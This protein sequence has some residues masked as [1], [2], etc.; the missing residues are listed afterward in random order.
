MKQTA[1]I[2]GAYNAIAL[3]GI[4]I[5]VTSCD[6]NLR[7]NGNGRDVSESSSDTV[8]VVEAQKELKPIKRL[9]AECRRLMVEPER[10]LGRMD[11]LLTISELCKKIREL[12]KEEALPL[13]DWW[14]EKAIEQ[15]LTYANYSINDKL[16]ERFFHIVFFSFMASQSMRPDPFD[17]W[18]KMFRFFAK[19]TDEITTVEKDVL[20]YGWLQT[21]R[22]YLYLQDLK[23]C[24]ENWVYM[25]TTVYRDILLDKGLTEEQ[26][27]DILRRLDEVKKYTVPPSHSPFNKMIPTQGGN[28]K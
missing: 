4:V 8:V 20:K 19:Y 14:I 12:P 17:H 13:F 16:S 5:V 10:N 2:R 24:I 15:P 18:D 26:K 7:E 25:I 3:F 1:I 9:E 21:S 27:A 6:N 22:L 11:E 23:L 28:D